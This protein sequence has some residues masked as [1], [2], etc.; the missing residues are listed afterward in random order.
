[1]VKSVFTKQFAS[2]RRTL[3]AERKRAGVTQV[4]L[5]ERLSPCG[6]DMTQSVISKV[7]RGERRLDVVEFIFFMRALGRDPAEVIAKVEEAFPR[8]GTRKRR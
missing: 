1:M 5:A 8:S 7:E 6:L 4:E 2:F 3:I